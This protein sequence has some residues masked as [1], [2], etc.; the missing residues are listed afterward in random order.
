M[1]FLYKLLQTNTLFD[2]VLNY[3]QYS[4]LS[5]NPLSTQKALYSAMRS[6]STI[7]THT[8]RDYIKPVCYSIQ[9]V[10]SIIRTNDTLPLTCQ[11]SIIN[12][13]RKFG[14]DVKSI[15]MMDG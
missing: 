8:D 13:L 10:S 5:S 15:C 11:K 3:R 14:M 2:I 4:K 9:L 12:N 1:V 7:F 6:S